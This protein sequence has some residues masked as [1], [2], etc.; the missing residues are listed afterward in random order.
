MLIGLV[1]RAQSGKSTVAKHLEE[2]F[3]FVRHAFA[4]PL[5]QML[6]NA[7]MCTYDELYHEKTT[8]SRW[9]LQKVGTDI[10]REQV[11]WDYWINKMGEILMDN[12]EKKKNIVIDDIR[13]PEEAGLIHC[14]NGIVIKLIRKNFVDPNAGSA[15]SS[16]RL[17]DEIGSDYTIQVKSGD[18]EG[19]VGQVEGILSIT[20]GL[21]VK[22]CG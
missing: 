20:N 17:V 3:G 6:L 19:L 2:K 7:K 16:E 9:L 4:D 12:T 22:T 13:F 1:G 8:M 10:F 11:S 15:H 18:I 14:F 5:K 21:E